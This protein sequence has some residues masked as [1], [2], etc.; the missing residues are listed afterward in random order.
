MNAYMNN[1]QFR[2]QVNTQGGKAL[3]V[4]NAVATIGDDIKRVKL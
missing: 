2:Q 3:G 1:K 4:A